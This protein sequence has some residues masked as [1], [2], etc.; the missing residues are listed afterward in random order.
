MEFVKFDQLL[1]LL[2]GKK[3]KKKTYLINQIPLEWGH[4]SLEI[5]WACR[6]TVLASILGV[7]FLWLLQLLN[8]TSASTGKSQKNILEGQNYN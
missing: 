1:D 2:I 6:D 5:L 8:A 4:W 7:T 3:K